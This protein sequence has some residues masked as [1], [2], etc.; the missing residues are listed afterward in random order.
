[1]RRQTRDSSWLLQLLMASGIVAVGIGILL[2]ILSMVPIGKI[3]FVVA[4]FI[5]SPEV[6]VVVLCSIEVVLWLTR[7]Y[8]AELIP[9]QG[10]YLATHVV[11]ILGYLST[12][13]YLINKGSFSLLETLG[14]SKL[15]IGTLAFLVFFILNMVHLKYIEQYW[16]D[17][18]LVIF[19]YLTITLLAAPIVLQDQV[20]VVVIAWAVITVGNLISWRWMTRFWVVSGQIIFSSILLFSSSLTAHVAYLLPFVLL[21]GLMLVIFGVQQEKITHVLV[22][23]YL[24]K[25]SRQ[26]L[27]TVAS[28]G[29]ISIPLIQGANQQLVPLVESLGIVI[30]LI[31]CLLVLTFKSPMFTSIL[32]VLGFI[33]SFTV[34]FMLSAILTSQFLIVEASFS[35]IGLFLVL[36]LHTWRFKEQNKDVITRNLVDWRLVGWSFLYLSMHLH[37]R[38]EFYV[39]SILFIFGGL[40]LLHVIFTSNHAFPGALSNYFFPSIAWLVQ[41]ITFPP[42]VE[43]LMIHHSLFLVF[44][45]LLMVHGSFITFIQ[46]KNKNRKEFLADAVTRWENSNVIML[47]VSLLLFLLLVPPT[48]FYPL[49]TSVVALVISFIIRALKRTRTRHLLGHLGMVIFFFTSSLAMSLAGFNLEESFKTFGLVLG[50]SLVSADYIMNRRKNQF[51]QGSAPEVMR[52]LARSVV[53]FSLSDVYVMGL[54]LSLALFFSVNVVWINYILVFVGLP[55]IW[56]GGRL[57]A[58]SLVSSG[59]LR[60]FSV[61]LAFLFM[62]FHYFLQ[63]NGKVGEILPE[64]ILEV[65]LTSWILMS[66]L[67]LGINEERRGIFKKIKVNH[68]VFVTST[69]LLIVFILSLL[70]ALTVTVASAIIFILGLGGILAALMSKKTTDFALEYLLLHL[71]FVLAISGTLTLQLTL[72]DYVGL[73]IV[74]FVMQLV[75]GILG[76]REVFGHLFSLVENFLA[77]F[78]RLS[79]PITYLTLSVLVLPLLSIAFR[80]DLM[81]SAVSYAISSLITVISLMIASRFKK[82]FSTLYTQ[83]F[84]FQI[85]AVVQLAGVL[86]ILLI[87]QLKVAEGLFFLKW[88]KINQFSL[89]IV[90][91][92]VTLILIFNLIENPSR[93]SNVIMFFI[94]TLLV[95]L[96]II[97]LTSDVWYMF[98]NEDAFVVSIFL[99]PFLLLGLLTVLSLFARFLHERAELIDGMT[100]GLVF[101]LLVGLFFH[102]NEPMFTLMSSVALILV[103]LIVQ[104][105]WQRSRVLVTSSSVL[106]VHLGTVGIVLAL[107]IWNSIINN[108]FP[109]ELAAALL[110][111][112]FVTLVLG[113]NLGRFY[114]AWRK[115]MPPPEELIMVRHQESQVM[116]GDHPKEEISEQLEGR[117]G[118]VEEPKEETPTL[119]YQC[120]NCRR[121]LRKKGRF[122]IYCGYFIDLQ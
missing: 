67:T 65:L 107:N 50:I 31:G 116:V 2:L 66:L 13:Q 77:S 44:L 37:L 81:L 85:S 80:V 12:W 68:G 36:L 75:I 27:V 28:L 39:I 8:R 64:T 18:I 115:T 7:R 19:S 32:G 26:Y 84:A 62:I 59:E 17:I 108:L 98:T 119:E 15:Y 41:M 70:E 88:D 53:S 63:V 76:A 118:E 87:R 103:Y 109:F 117:T 29:M 43:A 3:G 6:A 105:R 20:A 5:I 99:V 55:L 82:R 94:A 16:H 10:L 38:F 114:A 21:H 113:N 9:E 58:K 73:V 74:L 49:I 89:I 91:F 96:S 121:T 110:I 100:A 60:V 46:S 34:P 1:M 69:Y 120:P 78:N 42:S 61:L 23:R 54:F 30:F 48:W 72:N 92:I 25:T 57:I 83:R 51:F 40:L 71:S 22:N 79:I 14:L 101:I 106:F 4:E 95:D 56:L 93:M 122:C 102:V 33:M 35:S 47:G 104:A 86:F 24:F 90:V 111:W 112:G 52:H 11:Q 97:L 45:I